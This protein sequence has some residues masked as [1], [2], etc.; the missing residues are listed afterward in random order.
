MNHSEVEK[1]FRDAGF[2][3]IKNNILYDIRLGWFNGEGEVEA[4]SVEGKK[5]YSEEIKY[6]P[7]AEVV[8]TYHALK[9]DKPK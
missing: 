7:D 6:R 1:L 9:A 8:I 4:V 3:N 2:V 5:K